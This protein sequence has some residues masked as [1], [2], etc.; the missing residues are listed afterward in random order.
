MP[1]F[2]ARC[3]SRHRAGAP[4]RGI[5]EGMEAAHLKEVRDALRVS[6]LQ[7]GLELLNKRVLHRFTAVYQLDVDTLRNVAIV[8]KLGEVVPS[9]LLAVPLTSSFCQFVLRD[10]VFKLHGNEDARLEGHPYKG[11][12]NSYVGLPLSKGAGD[13]VGTFCHFDFPA[14]ALSVITKMSVELPGIVELP[15]FP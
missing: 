15:S 10:G 4:L 13:V 2:V 6:G 14:M 5:I 12:V 9:D 11:V 7:A 1:F 3:V 8:D